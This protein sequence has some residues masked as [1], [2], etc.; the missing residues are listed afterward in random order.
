MQNTTDLVF[1]LARL[2]QLSNLD[3]VDIH[4]PH[5]FSRIYCAKKTV[6]LLPE[7]RL[8]LK[9][10]HPFFFLIRCSVFMQNSRVI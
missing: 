6:C 8:C 9:V 2:F 7:A 4:I 10:A 3:V 1:N 5:S